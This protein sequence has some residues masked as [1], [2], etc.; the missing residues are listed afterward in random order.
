MCGATSA[1]QIPTIGIG[2]GPFCS[3][4][5]LVYHDLL[6]MLQVTPKQYIRVGDVINNALLKY[7]ESVT[8]GSFP[9]VR[10]SP[11]KI[12]AADVDGFF[13]VLQRL[14]LAKAAFAISEVVQKMETS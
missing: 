7:K 13:N 2:A 11:F 10:H 12:S 1:L 9:D 6:G 14:G 5:T 8:N 3:G 4:Q